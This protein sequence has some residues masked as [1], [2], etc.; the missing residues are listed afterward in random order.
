MTG[1][2]DLPAMGAVICLGIELAGQAQWKLWDVPGTHLQL[3][4]GSCLTLLRLIRTS[5]LSGKSP[6]NCKGNLICNKITSHNSYFLKF[7]F[8]YLYRRKRLKSYS[9]SYDNQQEKDCGW[10]DKFQMVI[11]LVL[12]VLCSHL[13][14]L[15]EKF[16]KRQRGLIPLKPRTED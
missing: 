8:H 2:G 3:E 13:E 14:I 16:E 15:Q 5:N 10:K 6:C 9:Q 1:L 12:L 11:I 7:P 4:Q